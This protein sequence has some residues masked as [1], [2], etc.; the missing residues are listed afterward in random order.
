MACF[1]SNGTRTFDSE[2]AR[3][4]GNLSS[5]H[6]LSI[7]DPLQCRRVSVLGQPCQTRLPVLESSVQGKPAGI[8]I[9]LKNTNRKSGMSL[10]EL[11][12]V[13]AII[14]IL[15]S[16]YLGVIAKAFVRIKKFLDG[17]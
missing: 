1:R 6:N 11:L 4:E 3:H 15:A 8:L 12:C 14:A 17:F 9:M 2:F 16:L 7:R 5:G 13:I 10:T